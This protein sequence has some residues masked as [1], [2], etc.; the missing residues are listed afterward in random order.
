MKNMSFSSSHWGNLITGAITRTKAKLYQLAGGRFTMTAAGGGDRNVKL[1]FDKLKQAYLN[2][3]ARDPVVTKLLLE[4]PPSL[5]L[6]DKIL[7]KTPW[8]YA[9]SIIAGGL[10]A[11]QYIGN[12]KSG[13]DMIREYMAE[14]GLQVRQFMVE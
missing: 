6:I 14:R 7:A 5:T 2:S 11:L 10:L 1:M 13:A 4:E 12:A 8:F 9:A 3:Q